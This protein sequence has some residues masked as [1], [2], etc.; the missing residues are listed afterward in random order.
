V[1]APVPQDPSLQ[2][3]SG[4]VDLPVEPLRGRECPDLLPLI[5]DFA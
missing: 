2:V 4:E 1:Q 3:Q 5:R